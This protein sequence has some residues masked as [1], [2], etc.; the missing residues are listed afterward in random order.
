MVLPKVGTVGP[1]SNETA[2]LQQM[3]AGYQQLEELPLFAMQVQKQHSQQALS[4]ERLK[5]FCLAV[6]RDVVQQIGPLDEQF[7]TGFFEDDDWSVR[8]L[9]AGFQLLVAK[10]VYIHHF[11]NRTFQGV[12]RLADGHRQKLII[13][14]PGL[15]R[16][17]TLPGS[18]YPTGG[19]QLKQ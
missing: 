13:A 19:P 6:R 9:Q 18:L 17:G 14:R 8:A 1:M 5:G 10:D 12:G 15:W 2:A 11:G 3:A 16:T 4:V 7:G